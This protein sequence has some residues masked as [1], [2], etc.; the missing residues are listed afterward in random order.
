[1]GPIA[2]P[3]SNIEPS[4]IIDLCPIRTSFPTVHE[5]N[6]QLLYI[7][8]NIP[9]STLAGNPVG[10]EAAVCITLLSPTVTN[11][12][13]LFFLFIIIYYH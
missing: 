10:N 1:M 11:E 2:Q 4:I 12:C 7:T 3:S 13:N 8:T 5:Y 9:I 6:V